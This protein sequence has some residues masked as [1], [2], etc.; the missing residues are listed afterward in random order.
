MRGRVGLPNNGL[1]LPDWNLELGRLR[2]EARFTESSLEAKDLRAMLRGEPVRLDLELA[3]REGRRELRTRLRC[4]LGIPALLGEPATV[5]APY[6][7]G[8]SHWET[9]LA[10]PTVRRDRQDACLLYT[11]R[12]V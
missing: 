10:I 2:G 11:S 6:F 5:L 9:L 7:S 4:R 3:G 12:C 8:K 1:T